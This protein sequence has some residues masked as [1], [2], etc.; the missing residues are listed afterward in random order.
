MSNL[1]GESDVNRLTQ[2]PLNVY[3]NIKTTY[4]GQ[5]DTPRKQDHRE[6][7]RGGGKGDFVTISYVV[8]HNTSKTTPTAIAATTTT[9][10]ES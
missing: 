1:W 8:I 5:I 4:F 2:S 7:R 9:E 6:K 10:I 3:R